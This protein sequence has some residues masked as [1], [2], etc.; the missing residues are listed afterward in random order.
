MYN[1]ESTTATMADAAAAPA[2]K[3]ASQE[4]HPTIMILDCGSCDF[5]TAPLPEAGAIKALNQHSNRVHID[6]DAGHGYLLDFFRQKQQL[7]QQSLQRAKQRQ[8]HDVTEHHD[9]ATAT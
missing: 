6:W 8:H 7:V 1:L 3:A 9:K 2:K 4:P 5:K